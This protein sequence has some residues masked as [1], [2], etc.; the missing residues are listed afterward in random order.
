V[1][2]N[3]GAVHHSNRFLYFAAVTIQ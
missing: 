2:N 3:W 1:S